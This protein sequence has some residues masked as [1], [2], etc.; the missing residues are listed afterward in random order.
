M[1][2][3]YLYSP[4]GGVSKHFSSAEAGWRGNFTT[5]L[6]Q[7]RVLSKKCELFHFFV[8]ERFNRAF[9]VRRFDVFGWV[10]FKYATSWVGIPRDLSR[11]PR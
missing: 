7:I 3:T 11:G 9:L 10:C 5:R 1:L 6:G 8:F 4:I 2:E